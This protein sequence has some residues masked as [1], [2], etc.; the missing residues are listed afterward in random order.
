MKATTFSCWL[1]SRSALMNKKVTIV[2]LSVLLFLPGLASAASENNFKADT[3]E[4]IVN[5]VEEK[6]E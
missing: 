3:T 5:L 6:E 1:P 2:F 4:Q